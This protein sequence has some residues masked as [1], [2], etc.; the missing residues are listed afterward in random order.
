[1]TREERQK[2]YDAAL[3]QY[4]QV[5]QMIMAIEEMSELQKEICKAFRP[6]DM[7]IERMIDEVAD[8]KIMMEQMESLFGITELVQERMTYKVQR[9]D[10]RLKGEE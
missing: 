3:W 5:S 9:L 1:M 6:Q 8:V 4:G 2:V 10:R 7:G